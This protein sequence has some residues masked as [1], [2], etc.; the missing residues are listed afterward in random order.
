MRMCV[1]AQGGQGDW[2]GA[3]GGVRLSPRSLVVH[4]GASGGL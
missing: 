4:Q 2:A 1:P 3:I